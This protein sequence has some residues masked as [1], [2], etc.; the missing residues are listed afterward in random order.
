MRLYN[1]NKLVV[2]SKWLRFYGHRSISCS[3]KCTSYEETLLHIVTQGTRLLVAIL[4]SALPSQLVA[5]NVGQEELKIM[6]KYLR[7]EVTHVTSSH[8]QS[9]QLDTWPCPNDKVDRNLRGGGREGE[10]NWMLWGLAISLCMFNVQINMETQRSYTNIIWSPWWRNICQSIGSY[11]VYNWEARIWS[12]SSG[13]KI[14][15]DYILK[16]YV[17]I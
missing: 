15:R 16:S 11:P 12:I 3:G 17:T 10:E 14:L 4:S 5:P 9:P 6:L 2:E 8:S 7:H 13:I 1:H